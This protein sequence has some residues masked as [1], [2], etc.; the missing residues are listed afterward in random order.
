MSVWLNYTRYTMKFWSNICHKKMWKQWMKVLRH[1]FSF[2]IY[3]SKT[4]RH[5]NMKWVEHLPMLYDLKILL[6]FKR[7]FVDLLNAKLKPIHKH[8]FYFNVYR[9]TLEGYLLFEFKNMNEVFQRSAYHF[10][11]D[12]S[13]SWKWYSSC[14]RLEYPPQHPNITPTIKPS[15]HSSRLLGATTNRYTTMEESVRISFDL[16]V[17]WK[18]EMNL[19]D[20]IHSQ[21]IETFFYNFTD[22]CSSCSFLNKILENVIISGK[23]APTANKKLL[24]IN[25]SFNRWDMKVITF[26]RISYL[27]CN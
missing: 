13:I 23:F 20:V 14:M 2:L 17:P 3:D 22:S 19:S 25:F 6:P 12:C 11:A 16:I 27:F 26:K 9:P 10:I 1:N 8:T 24:L 21:A 5:K 18:N 7:I 4:I 15:S